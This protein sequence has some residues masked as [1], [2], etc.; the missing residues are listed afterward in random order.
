MKEAVATKVGSGNEYS[1]ECAHP[2]FYG[3]NDDIET[4]FNKTKLDNL[5]SNSNVKHNEI[6]HVF[7][8]DR[9]MK[10]NPGEPGY[11]GLKGQPGLDATQEACAGDNV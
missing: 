9:G 10:G 3:Q 11:S 1:A 2:N 8:G 4:D 6:K 5:N 7:T